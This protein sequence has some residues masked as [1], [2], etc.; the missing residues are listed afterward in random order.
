MLL[1]ELE[2]P[3][4]LLQLLLLVP[5]V[6][7]KLLQVLELSVVLLAHLTPQLVIVLHPSHAQQDTISHHL[8]P[9]VLLATL[10]LQLVPLHL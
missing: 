5:L 8:P 10:E 6:T 3:L 9:L 7:I 1:V 4:V 2:L